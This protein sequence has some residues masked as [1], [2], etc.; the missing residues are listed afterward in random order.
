MQNLLLEQKRHKNVVKNKQAHGSGRRVENKCGNWRHQS[1]AKKSLGK[2]EWVP[3]TCISENSW[4]ILCVF[5]MFEQYFGKWYFI[6][7]CLSTRIFLIPTLFCNIL[8]WWR[9][10]LWWCLLVA[11]FEAWKN[12][13]NE[14]KAWGLLSPRSIILPMF[15]QLTSRTIWRRKGQCHPLYRGGKGNAGGCEMNGVP[16]RALG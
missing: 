15:S 2:W 3:F 5:L 11:V 9:L 6:H 10:L 16:C 8:G 14:E 7:P 4:G 12:Q 13:R 1:I